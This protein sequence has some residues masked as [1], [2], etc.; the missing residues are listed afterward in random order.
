MF[1]F[2]SG[3]V[4]DRPNGNAGSKRKLSDKSKQGNNEIMLMRGVICDIIDA[5][6]DH[7][8]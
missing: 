5:S 3:M 4:L 2:F 6:I 8:F 1:L 7:D